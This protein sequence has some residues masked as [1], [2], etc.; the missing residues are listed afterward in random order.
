MTLSG[1]SDHELRHRLSGD[2]LRVRTGPVGFCIRSVVPEVVRG[3]TALYGDQTVEGPAEFADFHI[4]IEP[5]SGL[6]RWVR[7]QLYFRIDGVSPFA[8][9]PGNQGMPMLEWGM[10]WCISG[11]CHQFLVLHAAVLERN[12]LALVMP[13]PS[14][15]GKSTL[16]AALLFNGWRL[17]SDELA[18]IATD[19]G[20]LVPL[21][22][23]VSLKNE[24]INV[25]Q[26]F[27]GDAVRFGSIV[28]D[29][30]KGTVGH[31][32]PPTDAVLRAGVRAA[33]GWVIF[34]RYVANASAEFAP[35]SRGRTLMRL[36]ENAF[37]Y[38]L[39]RDAGFRVLADLV[40]GSICRE[41]SYSSLGEAVQLFDR[42]ADGHQPGE[43]TP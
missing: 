35:L 34:P 6:R 18:L 9:L 15:S 3:L 14:G 13:A 1:L 5:A 4:S 43:G 25:I 19:T 2:G 32:A 7:P 24:S 12:G 27:A 36:I 21:P 28:R 8:P 22:R 29:T 33:P 26:R 11:S 39:H 41:F 10:N 42:L 17:L 37:N 40:E 16:C 31:F 38:N 30:V 20:H 23:P